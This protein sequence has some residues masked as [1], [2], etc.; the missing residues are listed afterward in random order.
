MRRAGETPRPPR[1]A[2]F[3]PHGFRQVLRLDRPT[4]TLVRMASE[5]P[6]VFSLHRLLGMRLDP[7]AADV[8]VQTPR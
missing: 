1:P 5:R 4:F 2:A 6:I 8:L 3:V 7:R